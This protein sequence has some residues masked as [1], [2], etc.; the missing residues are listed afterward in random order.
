MTPRVGLVY[1][2]DADTAIKALFGEAYRA[3]TVYETYYYPDPFGRTLRPERLRT[4]E[5]VYEQYFGGT[6]RFT[7]TGY[8]TRAKNLISQGADVLLREPRAGA[9]A[10]RRGRGRAPV[11]DRASCCAPATSTQRT[12]DP[13]AD[14]ELSNSPRAAGARPAPRR[15]C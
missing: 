4:S 6:L 15:R 14:V 12:I 3:P 2:T 10:R 11:D 9:L 8:V 5:V 7:A 1:R 13:I